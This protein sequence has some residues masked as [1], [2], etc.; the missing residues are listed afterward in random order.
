MPEM[1]ASLAPGGAAE[2]LALADEL[3]AGL[4]HALNNR[5]TSLGVCAELAT[6]GDEEMLKE[7]VLIAEV[8][9][10]QGV[11]RQLGLMSARG[12]AEALE[13]LP[14]LE[15]AVA[16]HALHPRMRTQD[17]RVERD[18]E[19][20]PVRAP[21]WALL[22]ALLLIVDA[23]KEASQSGDGGAAIVRVVCD[24]REVRIEA[25]GAAGG[26]GEGAYAREM[27]LLCGGT[28]IRDD[29]RLTLVLPSLASLRRRE[30]RGASA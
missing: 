30:G 23:A 21:R 29:D 2:W 19:P 14:V 3:H 13:V 18:G 6:M 20:Q 25:P 10:M 27:A 15:D 1:V 17:C 16:L 26:S 7:G 8:T 9:R 5:I 11:A 12:P 4:A 24:A 22:R 28:F